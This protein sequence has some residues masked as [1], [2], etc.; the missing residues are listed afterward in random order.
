M[1]EEEWMYPEIDPNS[2]DG[3]R[4][5]MSYGVVDCVGIYRF[6]MQY[7]FTE[8]AYDNIV[9]STMVEGIYKY[10]TYSKNR[11][12][13]QIRQRGKAINYDKLKPGMGVFKANISKN[14]YKHFAVYIG[15]PEQ[16]G[17]TIIESNVDENGK[18]MSVHYATLSAEAGY[19]WA[20]EL[21]GI[22][23]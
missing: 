14:E 5:P 19:V 3:S 21:K 17:Y 8:E 7:H 20:C 23:Y 12:S 18:I 15:W 4:Y 22:K 6:C 1:I 16:Y 10:S 2:P 11:K 9:K 13:I